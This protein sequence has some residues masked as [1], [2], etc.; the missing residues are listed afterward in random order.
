MVRSATLVAAGLCLGL[1]AAITTASAQS[2]DGGDDP[3]SRVEQ[4]ESRLE[5]L[6]E[7][8]ES[9]RGEVA[10]LRRR[11]GEQHL[12]EAREE[13][14]RQLVRE[15]LADAEQ[16]RS[17]T[18]GGLQA[19]HD[20]DFFLADADGD[21]R[22]ELGGHLQVRYTANSRDDSE[23]DQDDDQAG[24]NL[25]R[26]KLKFGGWVTAG[27]QKI[28]YAV[29]FAGDQD[30]GDPP[31]FEDYYLEL[32][33]FPVEHLTVRAGRFR[34]PFALQNTTSSARQMAV[35]RA[36][37]H[38]LF[39][40]DRSEGVQLAYQREHF[41]LFGA[42]N[43]GIQGQKTDFNQDNVDIALTARGELM[44]AGQWHQLKDPA[45]AWS[46]EPMGLFLGGGVH[47]Q[48]GESGSASNNN[49]FLLWTA[50]LTYENQGFGAMLAG[51]GLHADNAAGTNFDDFGL[52]AEGGYFVI[53]DQLQPFVRYELI[54]ADEGRT[55]VAD[56]SMEDLTSILTAGFNWY[57]HR[58]NAKFTLDVLYAFDPLF[59][60]DPNDPQGPGA[61]P[62][63]IG[64][65]S[66]GLQPDAAGQDGQLAI[67][68][69]YQLLW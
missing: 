47:Y 12:T 2:P 26:A 59:V 6:Q 35:D 1:P 50:D 9:Y 21:F 49:D 64:S 10:D 62:G 4:L 24:F 23:P 69:Q 25:R 54:V 3:A 18:T 16:R 38:E 17:F 41:R 45:I 19:G 65:S 60:G 5:Y 53:P 13:Q 39:R 27:E 15:V 34:Q 55:P 56:G 32:P 14:V 30:A 46:D 61:S 29:S 36:V 52:L 42:I 11:L 37:V 28:N 22:L 67:R 44:L 40:V 58:H 8:V 20:G 66:I 43:D 63:S 51:Y 7:T 48:I 57:Q 68:A 33:D 31:I